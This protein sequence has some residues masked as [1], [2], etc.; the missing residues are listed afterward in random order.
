MSKI[1]P[2]FGK[3]T[4]NVPRKRSI[5]YSVDKTPLKTE[6]DIGES[7]LVQGVLNKSNKQKTVLPDVNLLVMHL[8]DLVL[9]KMRE[10]SVAR[11][12]LLQD[13]LPTG[14]LARYE[15]QGDSYITNIKKLGAAPEILT[16]VEGE[17]VLVPTYEIK[18]TFEDIYS[19]VTPYQDYIRIISGTL[20]DDL[21]SQEEMLL[22][23][24]LNSASIEPLGCERLC[25][26][27]QKFDQLVK[28]VKSWPVIEDFDAPL[29]LEPTRPS[30]ILIHESDYDNVAKE[31]DRHL[32]DPIFV[33]TEL[34]LCKNPIFQD[35]LFLVPQPDMMGVQPI[36]SSL[37]L[38]PVDG[39]TIAAYSEFGMCIVNADVCFGLDLD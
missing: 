4:L 7:N 21:I 29:Q 5:H 16:I 24:L 36:R 15:R 11:L 30:F 9:K 14:T 27:S 35:R 2:I 6:F 31:L 18:A 3:R 1:S 13:E 20:V 10:R 23:R 32:G 26:F 19:V 8:R 39:K 37:S 25:G 28:A 34:L 17:E 38:I 22:G 33:D 12:I